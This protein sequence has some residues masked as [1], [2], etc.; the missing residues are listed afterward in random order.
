[1][2]TLWLLFWTFLRIGA[3]G[4]GGGYAMVSLIQTDVVQGFG[5]LKPQ[6]F[7]DIIA[8]AEMTP[9]PIAVNSATFV[10]FRI[11][12]LGGA[13]VA[14]IGVIMVS[15]VLVIVL[16]GLLKRCWDNPKVQSVL[17]SLRPVVI[18]LIIIAAVK[19]GETAFQGWTDVAIA[20][21]AFWLIVRARV[22]PILLIVAGG[23]VGAIIY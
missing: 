17:G 16:A 9:G 11:Q 2:K 18:A 7:T 14:T 23:I 12:G 5:W 20:L 22:H 19:I 10:G 13:L 8:I 3:F 21:G 15:F 4:F 1:M 6:E